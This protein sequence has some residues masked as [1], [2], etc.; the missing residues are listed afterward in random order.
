LPAT[1]ADFRARVALLY[2]RMHAALQ[3]GDWAAFGRAYQTLGRLLAQ[4]D[5]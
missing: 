4:P 3:H 1:P 2:D 5:Q